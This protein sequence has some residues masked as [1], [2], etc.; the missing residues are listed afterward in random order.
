MALNSRLEKADL[1][2]P[3]KTPYNNTTSSAKTLLR[4]R[5]CH[6]LQQGWEVSSCHLPHRPTQILSCKSDHATALPESF[7]ASPLYRMKHNFLSLAC[8]AR[9][10]LVLVT[11]QPHL[12]L[13][14]SVEFKGKVGLY[15]TP[16]GDRQVSK[17]CQSGWWD[18]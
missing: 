6:V 3:P 10:S 7:S 16:D 4:L 9:H 5:H 13:L 18:R 1:T 8:E 11:L 15:S 17:R 2:P 12:P 14:P